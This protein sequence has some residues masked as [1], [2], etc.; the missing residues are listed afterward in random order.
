MDEFITAYATRIPATL[1][2]LLL[3]C[4]SCRRLTQP[5]EAA[6]THTHYS[7]LRCG[8]C[9]AYLKWQPWPRDPHGVRLPRP[10]HLEPSTPQEDS[11]W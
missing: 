3:P 4:P 5:I 6:G 8:N 9:H 7:Q 1:T 11:P 10:T 2:H